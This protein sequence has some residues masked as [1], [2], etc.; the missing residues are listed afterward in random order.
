MKCSLFQECTIC[1]PLYHKTHMRLSSHRSSAFTVIEL[2]IVVAVISIL[3]AL[4]VAGV[5][6]W[7]ERATSTQ[8]VFNLRQI[9]ILMNGYA[10]E[11]NGYYPFEAYARGYRGGGSGYAPEH[12]MLD[13]A[14]FIKG[15]DGRII[16]EAAPAP[17]SLF[18]CP[19]EKSE[20]DMLG[21][22]W[23]QSHYAFNQYLVH[24]VITT[25]QE[26]EA[27]GT[28][29]C[30]RPI[31]AIANPSQV[32]LAADSKL[33]YNISAQTPNCKLAFRHGKAGTCNMLFVD[34]HVEVLPAFANEM[35]G[36]PAALGWGQYIEWGGER[37]APGS[38]RY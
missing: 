25:P 1:S 30:R 33:R 38:P 37:P 35:I 6:S 10:G 17:R 11:H 7:R 34:G 27:Q 19:S 8:C 20:R 36:G 24:V 28:N 12:F 2:L 31:T 22:L 23:F 9:G 16:Q 15:D 26:A 5:G 4:L 18:C 14:G 29:P 21:N 32:F 3:A 13:Y